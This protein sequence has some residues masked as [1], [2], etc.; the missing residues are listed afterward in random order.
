MSDAIKVGFVPLSA[1]PRGILVVFCDDTLKLGPATAKALGGGVDLVKR[2]A[3]AAAFKGKSAASL[4]I[5][6]R[7]A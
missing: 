3:A 4:D 2:A 6:A 7:R 5:L 1:A